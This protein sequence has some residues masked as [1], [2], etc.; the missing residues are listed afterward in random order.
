MVNSLLD[1]S[2]TAAWTATPLTFVWGV[3]STRLDEVRVTS[4]TTIES[5][6]AATI[7]LPL[8][9][10]VVTPSTARAVPLVEAA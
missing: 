5:L 4:L 2:V 1:A 10:N 8:R 9:E 7:A 3:V 6:L